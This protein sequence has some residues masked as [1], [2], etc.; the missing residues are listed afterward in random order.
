MDPVSG[1]QLVA[2][3]IQLIS[4]G[5]DTAKTC[6]DVYTNGAVSDY[7]SI[8]ETSSHL[9]KLAKELEHSLQVQHAQSQALSKEETDLVV[10]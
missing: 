1:V 7:D 3:V 4:F 9:H 10:L 8:N 6:R 2:S 5:I